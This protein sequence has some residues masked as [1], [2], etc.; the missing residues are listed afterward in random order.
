M[1]NSEINQMEIDQQNGEGNL[2]TSKKVKTEEKT[3]QTETEE[4]EGEIQVDEPQSVETTIQDDEDGKPTE[5]PST[6]ETETTGVEPS[7]SENPS[8]SDIDAENVESPQKDYFEENGYLL[9]SCLK[10]NFK[11][12]KRVLVMTDEIHQPLLNYIAGRNRDMIRCFTCRNIFRHTETFDD[13]EHL[14]CFCMLFGFRAICCKE[15]FQRFIYGYPNLNC[16]FN[17]PGNIPNKFSENLFEGNFKVVL[18]AKTKEKEIMDYCMDLVN[19]EIVNELLRKQIENNIP[20]QYINEE[21]VEEITDD[22]N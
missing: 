15:G 5:R 14:P 2:Q 13:D 6:S 11:P 18:M 4:I 7:T 17:I 1:E 16:F 20:T 21:N 10:K 19:S 22:D 9:P 12:H 8:T 3:P